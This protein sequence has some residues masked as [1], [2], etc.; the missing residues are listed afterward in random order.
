MEALQPICIFSLS[1]TSFSQ[2]RNIVA[3]TLNYSEEAGMN[4][5]TYSAACSYSLNNTTY[6]QR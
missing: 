6:I 4:H 1:S 3:V 2:V 5:F